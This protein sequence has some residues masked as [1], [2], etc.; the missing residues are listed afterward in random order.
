LNQNSPDLGIPNRFNLKASRFRGWS[1]WANTTAGDGAR[2]LADHAAASTGRLESGAA[3]RQLFFG[4][5]CKL[6]V[7]FAQKDAKLG[8]SAPNRRF[9]KSLGM[10]A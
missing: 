6:F 10:K 7:P 3:P 4:R 8:R 2:I 9:R 1:G 5:A